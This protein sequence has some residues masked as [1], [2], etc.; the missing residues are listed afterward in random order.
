M[1][2]VGGPLNCRSLDSAPNDKWGAVFPWGSVSGFERTAGRGSL[3]PRKPMPKG[4]TAPH[5]SLGAES[6]DLQFS[7]PPIENMSFSAT[8]LALVAG[9]PIP[10]PETPMIRLRA[11][12]LEASPAHVDRGGR[13]VFC[14]MRP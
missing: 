3:H 13:F 2:S 8:C 4:N 7:G 9:R 10:S 6:R 5:L 12:A 11:P 14:K 1:F